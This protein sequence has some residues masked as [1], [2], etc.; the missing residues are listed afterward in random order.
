VLWDDNNKKSIVY[1]D[2]VLFSQKTKTDISAFFQLTIE[3]TTWETDPHYTTDE[4]LLDVLFDD[5]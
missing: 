4:G 1:M 5:E 3:N 2:K